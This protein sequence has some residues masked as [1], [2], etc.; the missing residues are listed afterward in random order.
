M[1]NPVGIGL[2]GF[3]ASEILEKGQKRAISKDT[4]KYVRI[5]GRICSQ[6]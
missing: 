5:I 1:I 6:F 2:R 4:K 3:F